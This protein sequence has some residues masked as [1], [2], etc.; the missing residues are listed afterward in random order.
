MMVAAI[1][2]LKG[3]KFMLVLALMAACF[4]ATSC[5]QYN[6]LVEESER[7][8]AAWG[9]VQNYY[10]RRL[11]LIPNLVET[12]KGYASH[13]RKTL[14]GVTAMR[15]GMN[16]AY[17]KA[18]RL[19]G[20]DM[21]SEEN[22]K[23]YNQA[24][25][26]LKKAASIYINAVHEAYPDLKANENFMQLQGQLEDTENQIVV[27]RQDYTD[28]VRSYNVRVRRFPDLIIAKIFGFDAKPQFAADEEAQ[29]AP[30]VSFD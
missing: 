15:T 16:D 7:V 18:K 26:E 5:S 25:A 28:A 2:V 4:S 30:K 14:E 20:A 12:V 6:G 21:S 8:D 19:E 24:Q 10:Q 23:K 29:R 27:A 9:N 13:E 1:S 3:N 11:D 17:E 22:F